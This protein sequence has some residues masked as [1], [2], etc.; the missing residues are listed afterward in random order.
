MRTV[1][2]LM[3]VAAIL[4]AATVTVAA[5]SPRSAAG[6]CLIGRIVS[7]HAAAG[8]RPDIVVML[9][10][11]GYDQRLNV[12]MGGDFC[13]CNI[14]QG[15]LL[16]EA[17]APGYKFWRRSL[18]NWSAL[19]LDSDVT[20]VLAPISQTVVA[21]NG[22]L[23]VSAKTLSIPRKA[24][25]E[26][27]RF[28]RHAAKGDWARSLESLQRAVEAH[29]GY[30]DAWNNMGVVLSKLGRDA[31]AET[32][33]LKAIAIDPNASVAR[34]N[35]GYFCL[36]RGRKIEAQAELE[37]AASLNPRDALAQAYLGCLLNDAGR[38]EQA[39]EH[40]KRAL[41]L[42]P[43][44]PLALHQL[45]FVSLRLNRPQ[46]ALHWFELFL[47][48][49]KTSPASEEVRNLVARLSTPM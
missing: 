37:R 14:P 12:R 17:T 23:N 48:R 18:S 31:E 29:P 46:A 19:P 4:F 22:P 5:Q 43:G 47:K 1:S 39:E 10:G 35:F 45:G 13:F 44:M 28:L 33:F 8:Y 11:S 36:L 32:A 34:R 25:K 38:P 30:F 20:I 6:N 7:E 27:E 9:R 16:L 24:G 15:D 2:A 41:A 3:I 40:L 42:E 49:V 26:H 21:H